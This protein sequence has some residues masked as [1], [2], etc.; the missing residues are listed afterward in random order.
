MFLGLLKSLHNKYAMV[1]S[2]EA[3]LQM[4]LKL[5]ISVKNSA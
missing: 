5:G 2:L 1:A 4:L 3:A